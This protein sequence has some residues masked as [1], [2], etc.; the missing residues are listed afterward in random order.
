M[1][2]TR[3]HLIAGLAAGVPSVAEALTAP[4]PRL[5]PARHH[6]RFPQG[7]GDAILRNTGLQPLTGYALRDLSDGALLETHQPLLARPPAS[8]A[9]AL[10]ALWS[11]ARLGPDYRFETRVLAHGNVW[12]GVLDGDLYLVGGGDPHLDSDGLAELAANVATAGI[13]R[14]TGRAYI[15]ANSLPYHYEIEAGQPIYAGYNPSIA[16]INL[17]FN[18]VH[19]EWRPNS[20]GIDLSITARGTDHRP[21]VRGVGVELVDRDS[22]VYEHQ[23][24]GGQDHWTVSR[25]ALRRPGSVWLPVRQPPIYAAEVFRIVAQSAGVSLPPLE[26][27][28]A[29]PQDAAPIAAIESATVRRMSRAMLRY[30]TNLTAE[31]LGLRAHQAAGGAPAT[32]AASAAEMQAWVSE[33]YRLGALRFLNHSGLTDRTEINAAAMTRIL[34]E[35]QT[36]PLP[37]VLRAHPVVGADGAPAASVAGV[38]AKTGTL[39]F[40]RGLAGYLT[41]A[42]GRRFAFAI[43]AADLDRRAGRSSAGTVR[44]SA[45]FRDRAKGQE[46]ALLRAWAEKYG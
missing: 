4:R 7:V 6:E 23:I 44:G 20:G 25:R 42:R 8:V 46:H 31:V 26:A 29:V 22:P 1:T 12:G 28:D 36:G 30:S 10:T 43:F 34:V 37:Q 41:A 27:V 21:R 32:I 17:N 13:R 14:I 39:N 24:F 40:V 2:L 38:V 16:G 18:R 33:T 9:K 11:F 35:A 5:R 15:V 3:R 45:G 19:V